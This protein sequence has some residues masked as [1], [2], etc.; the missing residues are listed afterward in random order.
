MKRFLRN[1]TFFSLFFLTAYVAVV[2]LFGRLMPADMRPNIFYNKEMFG[3][4]N[5]ML[6]DLSR[7]QRVDILIVGASDAYRSYDTRI[8]S[9]NGYSVFN[10]GSSS[11]TP[12]Q[13]YL[14]LKDN[15]ERLSPRLVLYEVSPIC[16]ELDGV[17]ST[18]DLMLNGYSH[19]SIFPLIFRNPDIHLVNSF[20]FDFAD[21]HVVKRSVK[22]FNSS[23][24]KYISNG[25][26]EMNLSYNTV[27]PIG[28]KI[29]EP[30]QSQLYYFKKILGLLKDRNSNYILINAPSLTDKEFINRHVFDSL[31]MNSGTYLNG[32]DQPGFD[33]EK[34]FFDLSHLNQSGVKK[35]DSIVL[36]K[37]NKFYRH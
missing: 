8:F 29:W 31:F 27:K 17:E 6:S 10:A 4:T 9:D 33:P 14:L 15:I 20:L 34:D 11:Q 16:F 19:K 30:K 36:E 37:I 35:W 24:E 3:S 21:R 25:F 26:V 12:M 13:T 23:K 7:Q 1:I 2:Y 32:L 22:N 5:N 28:G 18:T